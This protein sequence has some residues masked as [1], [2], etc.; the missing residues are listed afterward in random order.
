MTLP[1]DKL[2]QQIAE[3]MARGADRT[4]LELL[5]TEYAKLCRE[6]NQ[7]LDQYE[8]LVACGQVR[9]AL[10]LAEAPPPV[11]HLVAAVNFN[12]S[13]QW[14]QQCRQM[15]LPHAPPLN[16]TALKQL[17]GHYSRTAGKPAVAAATPPV[18]GQQ[19]VRPAQRIVKT[20]PSREPLRVPPTK[21]RDTSPH[22]PELRPAQ[23]PPRS[24]DTTRRAGPI[25]I[26]AP[27]L[28][29]SRL[30]AIPEPPPVP[31]SFGS[32]M[33]K[34]GALLAGGGALLV[35]LLVTAGVV[36]TLALRSSQ[37]EASV[38][39]VGAPT[40]TQVVAAVTTSEAPNPAKSAEPP[41]EAVSPVRPAQAVTPGTTV[42]VSTTG[43]SAA[44]AEAPQMPTSGALEIAAPSNAPPTVVSNRAGDF[45]IY[46][47]TEQ[48]NIKPMLERHCGPLDGA[49]ALGASCAAHVLQCN[50]QWPGE[51]LRE[52][53]A[54]VIGERFYVGASAA[55][56][57]TPGAD[58]KLTPLMPSAH[59]MLCFAPKAAATTATGKPGLFGILLTTGG[60]KPPPLVLGMEAL[61]VRSRHVL[62][63]SDGAA[64]IK[65]LI[66]ATGT[67]RLT[68]MLKSGP[69]SSVSVHPRGG[70]AAWDY[71]ELD[72]D[73]GSLETDIEKSIAVL[74]ATKANAQA[75][76]GKLKEA[77]QLIQSKEPFSNAAKALTE[78]CRLRQPVEHDFAAFWQTRSRS[79]RRN[80]PMWSDYSKYLEDACVRLLAELYSGPVQP[81][82]QQTIAMMLRD[83]MGPDF[84]QLPERLS[85][86]FGSKFKRNIP[87]EVTAVAAPA[88]N[89]SSSIPIRRSSSSSSS[90]RRRSNTYG[91]F[92]EEWKRIFTQE[93]IGKLTLL[94]SADDEQKCARQIRDYEAQIQ[95]LTAAK[96][97]LPRTRDQLQGVRLEWQPG[98]GQSF[99]PL[100]EF[101]KT[102][103]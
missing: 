54:E 48:T 15:K 83:P 21:R 29:L 16:E 25:R 45:P 80:T 69:Q 28:V 4:T 78:R 79:Q 60:N 27:K 70:L 34:N 91:E 7:R 20:P 22:P 71:S 41:K 99:M 51:T 14:R 39:S 2:A 76:L 33:S 84:E 17:Q 97:N 1:A 9:E 81:L 102:R 75:Q 11:S 72:I 100:V 38:P 90:S 53:A 10:W 35:G 26:D 103:T 64:Q 89:I 13:E 8:R 94:H 32:G 58:W 101:R 67:V 55:M 30:P 37:K 44:V 92:A 36:V 46:V 88:P 59:W 82:E 49:E 93:N 77:Q 85:Q 63:S 96:N 23:T 18:P 24:M 40:R 65:W 62:L 3:A 5:A 42:G 87:I 12:G 52:P 95:N 19:I 73:F 61:E 86:Q 57:L 31:K 98:P 43:V 66:P 6:T 47:A 68:M 74:N 50:G 56:K